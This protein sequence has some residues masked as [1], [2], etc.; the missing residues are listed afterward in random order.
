MPNGMTGRDLAE[1]LASLHPEMKVLYMSGYTNEIIAQHGV[2]REE[3]NFL[4]KPFTISSLTHQVR[5]ALS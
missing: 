2:L 1:Q 3:V 4:E 5:Q